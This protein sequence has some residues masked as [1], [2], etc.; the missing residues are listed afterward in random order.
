MEEK[1]I[2]LFPVSLVLLPRMPLPLHIFE[3]RY[4]LLI[5]RC[6]DAKEDFGIVLHTGPTVQTNGCIAKI[7]SI[8][9]RYDDGSLDILTV[10]TERFE[11]VAIHEDRPYFEADVHLYHDD[12]P[13]GHSVDDLA[14]KAIATLEKFAGVTGYELDAALLRA[15]DYEELSFLLATTDLFG[16]EEKQELLEIRNTRKRLERTIHVIED[17]TNIR[18]MEKK[19]KRILGDTGDISHLFN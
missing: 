4:R 3:E 6:L 15:L 18:K 2:P 19:I 17:S 5:G 10:G 13:S 7:E 14:V 12:V 1:R 11:I 8:I 16:T 9:N